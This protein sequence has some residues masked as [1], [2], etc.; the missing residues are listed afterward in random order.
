MIVV[1]KLR[2]GVGQD[3]R[4]HGLGGAAQQRPELGGAVDVEQHELAAVRRQMG[5]ERRR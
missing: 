2:G 1:R 4:Q 3:A 5:I